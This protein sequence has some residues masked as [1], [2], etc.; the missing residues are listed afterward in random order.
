MPA[1][2][3]VHVVMVINYASLGLTGSAKRPKDHELNT[4]V[5]RHSLDMVMDAEMQV[6]TSAQFAFAGCQGTRQS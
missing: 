2:C 5:R 3:N 1:L 6:P 4:L